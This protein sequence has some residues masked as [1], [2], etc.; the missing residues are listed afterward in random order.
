MENIDFSNINETSEIRKKLVFIGA[1]ETGK[2]TFLYR[3]IHNHIDK[4]LDYLPTAGG[5]YSSFKIK[6]EYGNFD[7]DLWDSGGL[8]KY[9]SLVKIFYRDANAILIFY[10][11]YAV[12][13]FE[14]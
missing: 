1:G 9:Y 12:S 13:S 10:D 3:L 5:C 7:L 11:P 8:E 2:S 6:N 4:N 14:G